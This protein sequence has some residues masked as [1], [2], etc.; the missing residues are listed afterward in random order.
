MRPWLAGAR[1]GPGMSLA[2]RGDRGVLMCFR[3]SDGAFLWQSVHDKLPAGRVN[4]WPEEGIQSCPAVEGDRLYYVSNRAE[5]VCADTR[6]G[7]GGRAQILW[8]LDL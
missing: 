3:A 8:R 2:L 6:G 7:A 5:L 4:D 1:A